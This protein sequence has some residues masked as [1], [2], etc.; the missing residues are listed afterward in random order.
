MS[1]SARTTRA[2]QSHSEGHSA[3]AS[4]PAAVQAAP[5]PKTARSGFYAAGPAL[6][7]APQAKL[8]IGQAGDPFE[9]E[10]DVVAQSVSAGRPAPAI[11]PIPPSGLGDPATAQ[12]AE[13][14]PDEAEEEESLAQPLLLQRQAEEPAPDE[15]EEESLAQPLL[16][17]RQADDSAP[18]EA[19]A[20][21]SLAQPLL[22]QRQAD[23]PAP[24]EA[25]EEEDVQ[26][27]GCTGPCTCGNQQ[28][29]ESA[30]AV[31]QTASNNAAAPSDTVSQTIRS[32]GAGEPM[33][34]T[35]RDA[36]E[37][38][39][40]FDM[41]DV[42]V[43]RDGAAHK[44]SRTL[45]ARAFT[46]GSDIWLGPGE[47]PSDT[48]LMAHEATH[49]VQQGAGDGSVQAIQLAPASYQ[50]PE[51]G[52]GVQSRL[53][54]RFSAEIDEEKR[55]SSPADARSAAR[56]ADRGA[57]HGRTAE[58]RGDTRPSVNRPAQEQPKVEQS[59]EVVQDEAQSPPDK[60]VE[61]EQQSEPKLDQQAGKDAAGSADQA[62]GLAE[63]A[64]ATADTQPEPPTEAMVVPPAAVDSPV[65]A[66][67]EP[68][69]ADPAADSAV[70][71]IAARIQQL[72][73]HGALMRAQA[74][75][76]HSN[77]EIIRGNIARVS[78][79]VG[80]AEQGIATAQEHATYRR[81]VVG[82]AEGALAVSEQKQ[83]TV[84]AQ[85]PDFQSKADEGKADSGP[86][87]SEAGSL[88]GENAAQ[89]PDDAEAAENSREQGQA[90][91][92]V[93][94]GS[95]S[96]DSA[97]SQTRSRADS[98]SQDAARAAETNTRTR[99]K[100]D[101][102][103]QELDQT[104][105]R[106]S[107]HQAEATQARSQVDA[108]AGAP[109]EAHAQ[110]DQL[111]Q[112]SQMT[113]A[114]TITLEERLRQ[115]QQRYADG[116]QAIPPVRPWEGEI[117]E[118]EGEEGAGEG[119]VQLQADESAPPP[120][121]EATSA[122]PATTDAAPVTSEDA[123][124]TLPNLTTATPQAEPQSTP[125]PTDASAQLATAVEGDAPA[126]ADAQGAATDTAPSDEAQAE[127]EGTGEEQA[128][129]A[130]AAQD[131]GAGPAADLGDIDIGPRPER[132]DVS[133]DVPPWITGADPESVRTHEQQRQALE[134]QRRD[135]IAWFQQE[136][137]TNSVAQ[138]STGQRFSLVGRALGRRF[139][140]MV[141]GIKWPGWGGL[142]RMLLDPRSMLA[143]AVGGIGMIAGGVRSLF[144]ADQWRRDPLGNLLTS[145]ANIATGL[146]VILGSIVA[147]AGL[148]AAIMGALVLITFGAFAPIAAP[149]IS[150]CATVITTVGGWTIAVGKVALVLQALALIK[151]LIDVATAQTADDLQ[152]ETEE[153]GGNIS[154]SFQ[155]AMSI[156]GARGAT[157]GIR[158][159][160]SRVASATT[161]RAAAG[162][163]RALARQTVR[164][165]PAAV[166]GAARRVRRR[167][168]TAPRRASRS[169]RAAGRAVAAAPGRIAEGAR[170]LPSRVVAGARALPS[171]V[172]AGARALPGRVGR[173]VAG[174]ARQFRDD[175]RTLGRSF[176]RSGRDLR[177]GLGEVRGSL[178]S[179]RPDPHVIGPHA[180]TLR[181]TARKAGGDLTPHELNSE[182]TVVRNT[183]P[184]RIARGEYDA[185]VNLGNRHHWRRNRR[186][187]A[188][189][190]FSSEADLCILPQ[191][192][193]TPTAE[194][195]S[196]NSRADVQRLRANPPPRPPS[197]SS[198]DAA[199]WNDYVNYYNSRLDRLDQQLGSSAGRIR[200][201]P[202]RT[203]ESYRQARTSGRSAQA[204]RG[205]AFQ[206]DVTRSMDDVNSQY[207]TGS[208]VGVSRTRN[209]GQGEVVFPDQLI[210]EQPPASIRPGTGRSVRYRPLAQATA[211]SNKSRDFARRA[212]DRLQSDLANVRQQVVE[213]VQELFDKYSG[214]VYIR[215]RGHALFNQRVTVSEVVLVYDQRLVPPDLVTMI[216]TTA[217][218]EA[219]R[220]NPSIVFY[221]AFQ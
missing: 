40:G 143:G 129:T 193:G 11:S 132:V 13:A 81:E 39:T 78:G 136:L 92:Q 140:G 214:R 19:E 125:A 60:L 103:R 12:R 23:G 209:P 32:P 203:W 139:Q 218:A 207:L 161:A 150:F 124:A 50:H 200:A 146:A 22:L 94:E 219:R 210:F 44:A 52:G 155:A 41:G 77:A 99:G 105:E 100:I 7:I 21:E 167:V 213:D 147:L 28:R 165:I 205:R 117:P 216:Q 89:A 95:V 108:M 42:R 121:P 206:Q 87:A 79:Q 82:Q 37:T 14:A 204:L 175:L 187:G 62:A 54:G 118:G 16:L 208:D 65:D 30:H 51:D 135:E 186:S 122:A 110:A 43:H 180:E 137:G 201:G 194:R 220:L 198:G 166:R 113:T 18:D 152:R 38:G 134:D 176:R 148:V 35:V 217:A 88:A 96:M 189:C 221:I 69:Q 85:A 169:L 76:G 104:D 67:G 58:I 188:W 90:M 3:P 53:Q 73:D 71:D 97:I 202:P 142:A 119:V 74:G 20:E 66:A 6:S 173:G 34:P 57:V 153:I 138:I 64:F 107:Q 212:G 163:S 128:E 109:G 170:A 84:A 151:N 158:G 27:C 75:E 63:Q 199:L 101:Q 102:G 184:R 196:V 145:A 160:Q 111:D 61:G 9:R 5:A 31:I 126:A 149:V 56:S 190:R 83:A 15:A 131:G 91:N 70:G 179:G 4:A 17:Q 164:A 25:E 86:M 192:V 156:V 115:A 33:E 1:L 191:P 178:R 120:S 168:I 26:T 157:A 59:A 133:S 98:L 116:M 49:V 195:F 171:R 2:P 114:S 93:S 182:L 72:R 10:A 46:H 144:S 215:R 174:G 211:T 162:G 141:S 48:R 106:L 36:V 68:L 29:E 123:P 8:T 154:G 181:G 47:S 197:L 45:Q 55:K 112:H 24:D 127:A 185:E 130:E 80:A 177:R 172:V 159:V 183:R